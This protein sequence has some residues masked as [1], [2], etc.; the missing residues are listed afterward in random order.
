MAYMFLC[1]LFVLPRQSV[2]A[3]PTPL[4]RTAQELTSW[5]EIVLGLDQHV[6]RVA[7]GLRFTGLRFT[8]L[9]TPALI[10]VPT[11]LTV[12]IQSA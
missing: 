6:R 12:K 1:D 9:T 4:K 5:M 2:D 7:P 11:K 3:I 8:A 10:G